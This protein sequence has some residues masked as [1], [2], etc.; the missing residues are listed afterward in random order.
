VN[1][2]AYRRET[3]FRTVEG[4]SSE[5]MVER[6]RGAILHRA[7]RIASRTGN[8][9]LVAV[10][11]LVGYGVIGLLEAF[12][13]YDGDSGTDFETF[14]NRHVTGRMIDAVRGAAVHTR[15]DR[16]AARAVGHA[17]AAASAAAGRPATHTEVAHTL[18]VNMDEYWRTRSYADGVALVSLEELEDADFDALVCPPEAP[19]RMSEHDALEVLKDCI[20]R[21]RQRDR[22]MVVLFYARE[23]SLAEI[24]AVYGVTVS[25]VSQILTEARERMRRMLSTPAKEHNHHMEGAA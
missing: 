6:F 12:E 8:P 17:T 25:R 7:R 15:R 10:E 23:C 14:G 13:R 1:L 5:E 16:R 9:P 18:A 2:R 11:D 19:E 21:L 3:A 22:E 24:A 4:L 20:G